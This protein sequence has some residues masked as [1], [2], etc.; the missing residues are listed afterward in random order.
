[1]DTINIQRCI[2][3]IHYCPSILYIKRKRSPST[4]R[5]NG[6]FRRNYLI[7][8]SQGVFT[9]DLVAVPAAIDGGTANPNTLCLLSLCKKTLYPNSSFR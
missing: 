9:L 3:H 8:N 7:F 1:M 5:S 2:C 6:G 4:G